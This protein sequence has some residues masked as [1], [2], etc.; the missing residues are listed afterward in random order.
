MKKDRDDW[1]RKYNVARQDIIS[2]INKYRCIDC[3]D[4]C[5]EG[6]CFGCSSSLS[7]ILRG[8]NYKEDVKRN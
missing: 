7:T 3:R 8:F 4:Y 5:S 2:I 6:D 1:I